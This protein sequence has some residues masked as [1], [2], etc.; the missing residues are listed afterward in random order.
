[1]IE[2]KATVHRTTDKL[3]YSYRHDGT[4]FMVEVPQTPYNADLKDGQQVTL[5]IGIIK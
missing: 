5:V 2:Q 4:T 1:M 3:I